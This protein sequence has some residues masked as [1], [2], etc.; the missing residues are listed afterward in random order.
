MANRSGLN[1]YTAAVLNLPYRF[2]HKI[3]WLLSQVTQIK[4]IAAIVD[5]AIVSGANFLTGVIVGRYLVKE[6]F[7][8]YMLGFG[9][10]L[11]ILN[12]QT[13][14]ITTPY[15][16]LS[17]RSQAIEKRFYTGSTLIHHFVLSAFGALSLFLVS[18]VLS[19]GIGPSG[20]TEVA[21]A[22]A[23]IAFFI[24]LRDYCR[25]VYFAW[26]NI[27]SA[28]VL[29]TCVSLLQIC[30]LL[31]LAYAGKLSV[32]NAFVVSGS[33][34]GFAGI[35]WLIRHKSAFSFS[36]S[37]I[38]NDMK[39]NWVLAK[40]I[41]ATAVS[42]TLSAELYPWFLTG[43]Y[44]TA[45]TGEL[46]ACKWIIFLANPFMIGLSNLLIP[47]SAHAFAHNGW[48]GLRSVVISFSIITIF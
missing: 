20:L 11:F 30:G 23:F 6:E 27:V 35:I 31:L 40:W 1:N 5:Q 12:I 16:A 19:F 14:V 36:F 10:V 15:A 4:N 22:L 44:N 2:V 3:F 46:A 25:R 8:L 39:R 13:S 32:T 45:V 38:V 26:L 7:G 24:L 33:A 29:D 18:I 42:T 28:L 9:I 21:E 41:F 37:K 48:H 47:K 34:C 17:H 43:F